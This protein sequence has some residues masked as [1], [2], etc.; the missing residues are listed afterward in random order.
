M[1]SEP[2]PSPS[3]PGP[4]GLGPAEWALWLGYVALVAVLAWHHEPWRDE[5]QAWGIVRASGGLGELIANLRYEAHPPLWHLPLWILSR[6]TPEPAAMQALAASIG[7]AA[8]YVVL[9]WAPFD[10]LARA[11]VVFGYVLAYEYSVVARGYGLGALATLA[12]CALWPE[13][14]RRPWALGLALGLLAFTSVYGVLVAGAFAAAIAWEQQR[15]GAWRTTF[16][17]MPDATG[18]GAALAAAGVLGAIAAMR[19]PD[20]FFPG[21]GTPDVR[22]PTALLGAMMRLGW[23]FAPIPSNWVHPWN[24]TAMSGVGALVVGVLALAIVHQVA[25]RGRPLAAA[26]FWS[27]TAALFA[28]AFA[29]Y[30]GVV[31]HVLHYQLVAVA[32]LWLAAHEGASYREG[33]ARWLVAALLAPS[34]VATAWLAVADLRAPFSNA[35]ATAAWLQAHHVD[36]ATIM[37]APDYATCGV[38]TW[39]DQPLYLLAAR[40]PRRFVKWTRSRFV[41]PDQLVEPV[42]AALAARRAVV[43]LLN[44]ELE[45]A[46]RERFGGTATLLHAEVGALVGDED[47]WVYRLAPTPQ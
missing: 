31:R 9:R 15:T 26:F 27:G 43:L 34:V 30:P 44:H 1:S 39:L 11:L 19:P 23:A 12:A 38:G 3:R 33:A 37:A 47:F 13:R 46:E 32:A 42:R 5:L 29:I 35:R 16:A 45:E 22:T 17:A 18:A 21:A 20:D 7:A 6:F 36:P 14:H 2:T 41:S 28:F 4:L 24:S 25:L 10:R 40:E 8:A